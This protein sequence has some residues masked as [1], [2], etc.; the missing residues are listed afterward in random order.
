MFS[1]ASKGY[2]QHQLVI[3]KILKCKSSNSLA[4]LRCKQTEDYNLADE[5]RRFFRLLL[6]AE[7]LTLQGLPKS[8]AALIPADRIVKATGNA[9]PANLIGAVLAP[10]VGELGAL[11]VETL[12]HWPPSDVVFKGVHPAAKRLSIGHRRPAQPKASAKAKR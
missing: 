6:G 5:E 7:R 8:D 1:V 10:M 11:P 9:Y 3:R 4:N 2:S 12:R